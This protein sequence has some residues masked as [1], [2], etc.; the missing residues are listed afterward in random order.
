LL[1]AAA[2]LPDFQGAALSEASL[3]DAQMAEDERQQLAT[4]QQRNELLTQCASSS[5]FMEP[6]TGMRALM[7]TRCQE[8][9]AQLEPGQS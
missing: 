6:D 3:L 1:R 7:P 2:S 8:L 4:L 9:S 5:A